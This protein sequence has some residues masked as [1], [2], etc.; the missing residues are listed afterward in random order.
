MN[1]VVNG[2]GVD[3][4]TVDETNADG[5]AILSTCLWKGVRGEMDGFLE[6]RMFSGV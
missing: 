4:L 5:V 3:T 1:V 2:M 6:G